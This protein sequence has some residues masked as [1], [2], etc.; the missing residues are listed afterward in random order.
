ME[1]ICLFV[2]LSVYSEQ[3]VHILDS[4][5]YQGRVIPVTQLH[6]HPG[7]VQSLRSPSQ[8]MWF[9]LTGKSAGGIQ[10]EHCVFS[11][12]TSSIGAE[13]VEQFTGVPPAARIYPHSSRK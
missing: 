5:S 7:Q 10:G 13:V 12:P 2:K 1:V 8:H 3:R 6:S 11:G 4:R 9:L